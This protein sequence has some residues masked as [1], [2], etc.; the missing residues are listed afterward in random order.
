M[1]ESLL[2]EINY[3]ADFLNENSFEFLLIE[4]HEIQL[5]I[6]LSYSI[7]ILSDNIQKKLNS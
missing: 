2:H 4:F 7:K 1:Y 3:A 5:T 6:Q